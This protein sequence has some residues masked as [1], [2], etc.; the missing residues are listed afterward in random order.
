MSTLFNRVIR[1]LLHEGR[2]SDAAKLYPDIDVPELA[3]YDPSGFAAKYIMWMA[4]QVDAGESATD[5]VSAVEQFD[6][7]LSRDVLTQRNIVQYRTLTDLQSALDKVGTSMSGRQQR[8]QAKKGAVRIGGNDEY[9]LFRIDTFDACALYGRNTNWC[10]TDMAM[11]AR[12]T[13]DNTLFY[14]AIRKIP[15]DNDLDKV[16][17][18]VG[19]SETNDITDIIAYDAVDNVRSSDPRRSSRTAAIDELEMQ[20]RDDASTQPP[21]P[22]FRIGRGGEFSDDEF[23]TAWSILDGFTQRRQKLIKNLY[24]SEPERALH[25]TRLLIDEGD[26]DKRTLELFKVMIDAQSG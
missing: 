20:V 26:L 11:W 22:L 7:L 2:V 9:V 3:N 24:E 23:L 12:Y 16:A 5:V 1:R 10:I 18:A 14:F 6:K 13:L 8:I 21:T 25:L 15:Q 19:R 17:F 4:K